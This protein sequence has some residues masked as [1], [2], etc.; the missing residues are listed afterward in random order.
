MNK[1][2][3]ASVLT[4]AF[5]ISMA[6]PVGAIT[7]AEYQALVDQL[8]QLTAQYNTL[9]AQTSGGTTPAATAICFNSDLSKGMTSND[10]KNLQIVLNKDAST[11]V[12]SS[13]AGSPGNETTYFG[14]LTL[15]AVKNFQSSKGISNTG[16]VGPLTRGALN[17]LYC[18]ASVPSTTYPAGCTSAVG[19]SITTGLS[20]SGAVT[21][22]AGC[23]S[24]AGYSSTTG[25]SCSGTTTVAATEGTLT[26][27]QY[28]IPGSG[29][30]IL[31]GDNAQKE[32]AAYKMKATNSDIRVK[33]VQLQVGIGTPSDFPWRDLT[34][35]SIWDGSTMLK[36]VVASQANFTEVTFGTTY[37][38]T[39][40]GLDLLIAKDAEKII[41]V[42][43][44]AVSVPQYIGNISFVIPANGVRGV[45]SAALNVYGPATALTA[46]NFAVATAQAPT[47][48]TTASIDS[49]VA[50]NFIASASTISRVELMKV[51]VKVESVD[52]IF[53][54]GTVN[55][56]ANPSTTLSAIELY[57]GS[58]LLAS[59]ATTTTGVITF[60]TFT[61]PVSSDTTK[62][63]T[64][65]G[66]VKANPTVGSA[67]SVTLPTT[68]GL[69]GIDASGAARG[70]TGAITGN[71]LT[72]YTAAP[73]F[74]L[75]SSTAVPSN[76]TTSTVNDVGDF[77]IGISIT[78]N[79]G[80]IYI[81]NVDHTTY[82][83]GTGTEGILESVSTTGTQTATT[84]YWTC[85]A[86]AVEDAAN[87]TWRIPSGATSVC[88]FNYHVVNT[89]AAG[90][91]TVSVASLRWGTSLAN[92]EDATAT[93]G[94][95]QTT[96]ISALKA[97]TILLGI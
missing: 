54:G 13:G 45:D 47:I 35:I 67:V 81:P 2:I 20:C 22:P 56:T 36:E 38:M 32:V 43:A 69:T 72:V 57:D 79:S 60:S 31:Y 33:R 24:A 30:V 11:Q 26:V 52:M 70:N 40:D 74:S 82:G 27:S 17:A 15:A 14:S 78:A 29:T 94:I 89:V 88:T 63:L 25:L 86:S 58:T 19:F 87:D 53:K 65:K 95:T 12:A 42:K 68:T 3:I 77:S 71:A 55:V 46:H 96:G 64:L 76:S 59:A 66:V 75:A 8:A 50:G 6:G 5:A 16:Y 61:L 90:Y 1:K 10:A 23:A 84:S 39:L 97:T 37:T 92:L 28:A 62:V 21:Y 83:A 9:L 41:S 18:T 51:N 7:D 85:D 48:T 73:V 34:A 44:T 91:Y 93:G 80:D 4:V 49:P